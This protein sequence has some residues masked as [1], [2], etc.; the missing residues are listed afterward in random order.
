VN[1]TRR[2]K[3]FARP[4]KKAESAYKSLAVR[5]QPPFPTLALSSR[6]STAIAAQ[7]HLHDPSPVVAM[8]VTRTLSLALSA[9]QFLCAAIVLGLAAHF[10]H[11]YSAASSPSPTEPAPFDRLVF[12]VVIAAIAVVLALV[13]IVPSTSSIIHWAVD[14]LLTAAWF[15][16]FGVLQ[17]WYDNV[18]LC[19]GGW[20]WRFFNGG[21]GQ[22]S[23]VQAFAFLSA[24][25]WGVSAVLG[26]LV[27]ARRNKTNG[28]GGVMPVTETTTTATG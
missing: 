16:V 5:H 6:T 23:A 8:I 7:H 20:R 11:L 9:A 24:V 27:W 21:C 4:S 14:L 10:L 25:L 12:S 1:A 15:A 28:E 19:G 13:W 17:D 26:L 22:W 3:L 2:E 18:L